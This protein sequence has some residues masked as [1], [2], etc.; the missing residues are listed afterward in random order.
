MP[1]TYKQN[2][3]HIYK[4]RANNMDKIREIDNRRKK[5]AYY[6]KKIRLEFLQILIN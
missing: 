1:P 3:E 5:R 4:W 2:K 6:W